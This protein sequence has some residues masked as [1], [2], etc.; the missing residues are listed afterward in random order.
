MAQSI[1]LSSVGTAPIILN[2]VARST[3]V[4]LSA[5]VASSLTAASIEVTLDDPTIVGGPAL[6]WALLSSAQGM[7]GSSVV[8]L[9]AIYTVLSPIGGVRI[10]STTVTASSATW[11]LKALQSITA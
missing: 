8:V 1:T 3:T 11:I 4:I 5:T 7:I 2:P 10:N 9:S 6:T